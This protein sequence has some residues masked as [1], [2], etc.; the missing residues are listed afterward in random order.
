MKLYINWTDRTFYTE[1][2]IDNILDDYPHIIDDAE[3]VMAQDYTIRDIIS[4]GSS[5]AQ[6]KLDEY[7]DETIKDF[8]DMDFTAYDI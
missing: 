7:I 1:D 3:N 4:I 6:K 8:I 5:A 2:T